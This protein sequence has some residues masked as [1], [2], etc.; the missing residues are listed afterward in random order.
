MCEPARRRL[1]EA[2]RVAPVRRVASR[3]VLIIGSW[4]A[5]SGCA[6]PTATPTLPPPPE[7]VGV[8]ASLE[9]FALAKV[10]AYARSV[11]VPPFD[12]EV[13]SSAQATQAAEDGRLQLLVSA[14]PP[15]VG[16]FATPLGFEEIVVIVSSET[17][18]R[19]LT[20]GQLGNVFSGRIQ[21]WADV[22]GPDEPIQ[23][24]IPPQGDELR[25]RF[26]GLAMDGRR[27]P[28]TALLAPTPAAMAALVGQ[29]SG[30]IGFLP[31]SSSA[32]QARAISINGQAP[33]PRGS[34]MADYP[35]R[36]E[37]VATAPEEPQGGVRDWLAWL[38]EQE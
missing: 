15:P 7:Q 26:E 25:Q 35:L 22:A 30:A 21:T 19:D 2:A 32:E 17:P 36:F 11:G 3:L 14:A 24:V 13:W 4:Y 29:T 8:S 34:S 5:I 16:W 28:Q 27:F 33:S 9:P 10:T 31:L 37:V 20:L 23:L 18:I 38:Q 6:T 1:R 12:L